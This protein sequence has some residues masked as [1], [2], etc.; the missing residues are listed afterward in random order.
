MR[1]NKLKQCTYCLKKLPA[2]KEYFRLS[3]N[4]QGFTS[5]CKECLRENKKYKYN[6]KEPH[7]S[8]MNG[9]DDIY[10]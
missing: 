4:K 6:Q 10:I 7:D 3:S 2:T 8:W 5:R 1:N 9:S